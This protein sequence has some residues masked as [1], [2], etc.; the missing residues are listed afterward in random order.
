MIMMTMMMIMMMIMMTYDVPPLPVVQ[1]LP[2]VLVGVTLEYFSPFLSLS[3]SLSFIISV[4]PKRTK[5]KHTAILLSACFFPQRISA[6]RFVCE[7]DN[8][9]RSYRFVRFGPYRC[10]WIG[11]PHSG[12]IFIYGKQIDWFAR[13]CSFGSI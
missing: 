3:L 8:A 1:V 13:L 7:A 4:L 12:S 11:A 2:L 10:G 6:Q 9:K 5:R